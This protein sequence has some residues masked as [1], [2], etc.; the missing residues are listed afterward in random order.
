MAG[1]N[2]GG[3]KIVNV[4]NTAINPDGYISLTTEFMALT[5]AKIEVLTKKKKKALAFLTTG[6]RVI[7]ISST[8]ISNSTHTVKFIRDEDD[9]EDDKIRTNIAIPSGTV[10]NLNYLNEIV[11][12]IQNASPDDAKKFLFG[13]M[14]ITRCR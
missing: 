3:L 14:L 9:D 12:F 8:E 10:P 1:A 5:D 4:G 13:V 6:R 7:D 11:G 2:K